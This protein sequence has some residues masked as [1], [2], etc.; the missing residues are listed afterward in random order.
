MDNTPAF[1]PLD[2]V[3]VVRRRIWWLVV[4][5]AIAAVVGAALVMYL[6]RE[7]S[8]SA[9]LGVTLPEVAPELVGQSQRLTTEERISAITQGV[10]SPALIER[11]VRE[12]GLDR[13]MPVPEAVQQMRSKTT[14]QVPPADPNLPGGTVM[15][16]SVAYRDGNPETTQRIANRLAEVFVEETSRRREVRAEETAMF[17][18]MQLDASQA[19]LNELEGR[20]R[21]AK[22]SFMGALPEQ[23]NANVAMVT[24]LQQ[25]LETTSNAIRGE[26]DRLSVIERQIE[27]MKGAVGQ[28]VAVPGMPATASPAALRV[29][30]LERE[31]AVARGNY[32]DKHPEV[33]RLREELTA[34]KTDAAT[35]A[36]RP[37]E[38]RVSTLRIDPTYRAL[39]ADQQQARLRIRELQRQEEQIRAQIGMYRA[40]VDSAP[41]VEQQISTLQREYDL[42]K[43]QYAQL[44]TKLRSAEMAESLVRN[45]G[46]EKFAIV[47]RAPLPTIPT[48]PNTQRLMVVAL[49]L[50][51]VAGTGLALGREYLDRSIH[52]TRALTDLDLPVLGEIPRIANA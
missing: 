22:E 42:E 11:V 32:T 39:L 27:S 38:E 5:V 13:N 31:L 35:E 51:L 46:G 43:E 14:V 1:H 28:E 40:R 50:G 20:L 23:T 18:G 7:Y 26:Q 6:P 12:E 16:F 10:R 45:R 19:R 24:G 47:A 34:A 21:T 15:Q 49:L 33:V 17:V 37:I 3:S 25:Q 44:T 30:Q 41:R 8:T 29:V 36:S 48:S 52:D 9:T 4:P 2:Y